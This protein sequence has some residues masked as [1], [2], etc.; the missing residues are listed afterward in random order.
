MS[1]ESFGSF[2]ALVKLYG[3]KAAIGMVGA[4]ML[5]IVL[6]PLNADGTFN[7]REFVA[8]L[9]CA[10]VFSCLLGSTVYQMLCAQLP[11]IGAMVNASAVDLVVGAPAWWVSRA[12]ALWFQRRSDKDIAEL[13]RAA[14]ESM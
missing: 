1:A 13:A 12:V 2:A 9:A 6:P 5:Y 14:K 10:G 7:K 8:R 4:A 3:F 11:T